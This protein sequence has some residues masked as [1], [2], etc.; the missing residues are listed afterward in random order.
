MH[1]TVTKLHGYKQGL[2]YGCKIIPR[3]TSSV[4]GYTPK[5]RE[6]T[7]LFIFYIRSMCIDVQ[8][9]HSYTCVCLVLYLTCFHIGFSAIYDN[10]EDKIRLKHL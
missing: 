6:Y 5:H 3:N 4:F 1:E 2:K 8:R 10:S 9:M 7:I